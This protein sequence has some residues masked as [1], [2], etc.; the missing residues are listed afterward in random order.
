MSL[1]SKD[2]EDEVQSFINLFFLNFKTFR[3]V[4]D[5]IEVIIELEQGLGHVK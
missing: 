4:R 2:V 5:D 3:G 1:P